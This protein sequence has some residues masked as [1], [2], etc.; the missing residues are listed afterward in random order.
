MIH[1]PNVAYIVL[2]PGTLTKLNLHCPHIRPSYIVL[3][4]HTLIKL[5]YCPS[6]HCPNTIY[7]VQSNVSFTSLKLH[8]PAVSYIV[9]MT[10]VRMMYH[11]L[12]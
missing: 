12:D 2:M 9:L 11:I 6:L 7:I 8:C 5:M 1:C 3:M 10:R 4:P